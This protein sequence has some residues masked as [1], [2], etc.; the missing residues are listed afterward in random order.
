MSKQKEKGKEV[1]ENLAHT[2]HMAFD[3]EGK[4]K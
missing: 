4:Q 2:A 1:K 3:A